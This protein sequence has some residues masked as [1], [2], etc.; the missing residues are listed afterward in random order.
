M[1]K[2]V[3][4]YICSQE[5]LKVDLVK[6]QTPAGEIRDTGASFG[7]EILPDGTS[8]LQNTDGS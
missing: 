7:L 1:A 4:C 8:E 6:I 3:K 2:P 5:K